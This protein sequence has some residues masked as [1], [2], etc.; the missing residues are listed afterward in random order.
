MQD[1]LIQRLFTLFFDIKIN[2]SCMLFNIYLFLNRCLIHNIKKDY[3]I[4]HLIYVII[5]E[6]NK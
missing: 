4:M 2:K 1:K 6:S 5:K 3:N